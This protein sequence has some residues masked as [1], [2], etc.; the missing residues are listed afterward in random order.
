MFLAI[1]KPRE[2]HKFTQANGIFQVV[3][4][5][6]NTLSQSEEGSLNEIAQADMGYWK[7]LNLNIL[8]KNRNWSH[9]DILF[10]KMGPKWMYV[11]CSCVIV[12]PASIKWVVVRLNEAEW[13]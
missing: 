11:P 2:I 13:G 8:R 4:C 7:C 10:T 3:V 9:F 1:F 5:R 6:Y 12:S